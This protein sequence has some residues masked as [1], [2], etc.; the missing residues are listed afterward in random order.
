MGMEGKKSGSSKS[1]KKRNDKPRC[2]RGESGGE[3]SL[4]S[5]QPV[6][7]EGGEQKKVRGL[8]LKERGQEAANLKRR[9]T[10]SRPWADAT[11]EKME[12]RGKGRGSIE[13]CWGLGRG[14]LGKT[15][16]TI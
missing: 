16:Y 4:E 9:E 13:R 7:G 6:W 8:L 11:G 15:R 12:R 5:R 3:L 1:R 14:H 2:V 10:G